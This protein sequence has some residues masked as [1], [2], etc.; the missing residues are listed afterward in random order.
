VFCCCKQDFELA[1]W[2]MTYLFFAPKRV[3]RNVYYH[4]QT[5]NTWY[6]SIAQLA[7]SLTL[8]VR[9]GR[10]MIPLW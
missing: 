2:Q 8:F 9:P 5:K 1:A 7:I 6:G 3:Y 4:K 10:E